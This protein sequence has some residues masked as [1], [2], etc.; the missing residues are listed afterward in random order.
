MN[1]HNNPS[2]T[3]AT[4]TSPAFEPALAWAANYSDPKFDEP[5]FALLGDDELMSS[6]SNAYENRR[7]RQVFEWEITR[8]RAAESNAKSFY[9]V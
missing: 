5:P 8:R 6:L 4:A 1:R 7:A 3:Q 9:L 2:D